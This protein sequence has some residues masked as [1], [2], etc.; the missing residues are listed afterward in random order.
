MQHQNRYLHPAV[1]ITYKKQLSTLL[2]DIKAERKE[3]ILGGDGRCDS[4]DHSESM[5][6][7]R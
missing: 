6:V 3:L 5:A 2:E 4:P 1:G 7:I